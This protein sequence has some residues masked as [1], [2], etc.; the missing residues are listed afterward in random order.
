MLVFSFPPGPI[1][2]KLTHMDASHQAAIFAARVQLRHGHPHFLAVDADENLDNPFVPH[3]AVVGLA[4]HAD[5]DLGIIGH[6]DGRLWS[7]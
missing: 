5:F 6:V 2:S 4:P 1:G 3:L 7:S